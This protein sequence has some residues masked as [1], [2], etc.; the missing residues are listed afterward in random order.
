MNNL[1]KI[2]LENGM[3]QETL[4]EH[5]DIS[6]GTLSNW[7]T[8]RND[9]DMKSLKKISKLFNV[10][11]DEILGNTIKNV[12]PIQIRKFPMLGDI[13]AGDPLVMN[14]E[15]E[16]YVVAEDGLKADF[17][18]RVKG[19][20]MINAR[21]LEGDIVFIKQQPSVNNGEIA[22][23]AINDEATLKRVFK[24]ADHIILQA[25]NPKFQPIVVFP[26]DGQNIRILGKAV[27]FNSAVR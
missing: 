2:R 25:E 15:Y 5:L 7:E 6:Q 8:E 12:L 14:V 19:N 16:S 17:C 22:A 3:K 24:Y 26:N 13:A 9:I 10:T 4:A 21:I 20:S 11:I 23:V 18:I 27:A 1:Q